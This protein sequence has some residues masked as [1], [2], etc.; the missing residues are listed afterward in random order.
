MNNDFGGNYEA[1]KK[2]ESTCITVKT[3]PYIRTAWYTDEEWKIHELANPK[4]VVLPKKNDNY[5]KKKY[6]GNKNKNNERETSSFK[7]YQNTHKK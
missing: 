7:K 1:I 4:P 6:E 3:N 5:K 2:Y